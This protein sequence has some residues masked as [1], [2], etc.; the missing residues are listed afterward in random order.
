M[1]SLLTPA[2]LRQG[3]LLLLS[4]SVVAY[5]AVLLY[6][7]GARGFIA[8]LDRL[9]WRWIVAGV[10]LASMD[11][12]GGG[13]RLWVLAR[14]VH[15]RPPVKGM[16]IAGGM[17]AWGSYV[18][19]MQAGASPMMVYAMKRAGVPLAK[20]MTTVL[21]SFI[22]TVAFFAICGP[23]AVM[24]GG[25]RALAHYGDFLGMSLLDLY[26]VAIGIF[27]VLGVVLIGVMIAPHRLSAILHRLATALGQRSQL[28]ASRL[29]QLRDGI[30][31]ARES[32]QL[33]NTPRG[34]LA[35][36]WATIL[37][38]PSH[39]NKLLAGY[40]ALRAIGIEV[41]FVDMLLLQTLISSLL[42]FV[43]TPG[44]AGFAEVLSTLVMTI[45]VPGNLNPI[46]T[47][48]WQCIR[49]WFTVAFGFV[50]FSV[51]VRQGLKAIE[52]SPA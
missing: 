1:A 22:A 37:S 29:H 14:Q 25:G 42:Y 30:E 28:V 51:W 36:F 18:T 33:F 38:G 52:E 6:G 35:L 44:G 12:I 34:W 43:P 11:W 21:M 24:L 27:A 7:H 45:Y 15:P 50:V 23:L 32:M 31:Q 20:A 19:P 48:V 3:F 47:L 49:M 8:S 5:T 26:K 39:A 9:E 46:Y 17:G 10:A 4:I 13:L 2:R 40:V 16:I 41:Q